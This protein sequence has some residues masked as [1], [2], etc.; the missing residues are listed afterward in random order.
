METI[1]TRGR[2]LGVPFWK[3]WR[4]IKRILLK[5]VDVLD[6]PRRRIRQVSYDADFPSNLTLSEGDQPIGNKVA[7]LIVY[8]PSGLAKSVLVS[9]RHLL[10]IGYSPVVVSNGRLRAD[11]RAAL[12]KHASLVV[13]RPNYGYDFGGYRDGLRLLKLRKIHHEKLILMND[14]IWFPIVPEAR[15]IDD[16]AADPSGFASPVY[17]WNSKRGKRNAHYQS[18]F[19]HIDGSI[20]DHPQFD[21]YWQN[22]PL[23]NKKRHVLVTGEKGLTRHLE[24]K[25]VLSEPKPARVAMLERLSQQDNNYL[26]RV[27][28]YAAYESAG[29]RDEAV[30]LIGSFASTDAWRNSALLHMERALYTA[31]PMG[32]FPYAGLT[33]MGWNFMK[34]SS[35]PKIHDGMRLQYLRAVENGDLPAPDPEILTEILASRMDAELTTDPFTG[36]LDYTRLGR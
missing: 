29:L 11:D 18:Y 17:E 34:K 36:R 27:L 30:A 35:Y 5:G 21:A 9:C 4:E 2:L 16:L 7:L 28:N 24:A 6:A 15:M 19:Y 10:S 13:E 32:T 31:Q 25:G 8:Q 22:Y 12:C 1:C 14:S 33:I 20:L 3:V 23:S 26:R